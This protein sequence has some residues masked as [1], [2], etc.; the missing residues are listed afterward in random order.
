M[1]KENEGL[2]LFNVIYIENNLDLRKKN[3]IRMQIM[4]MW[5]RNGNFEQWFHYSSVY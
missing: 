4:N 3:D 1:E 5:K 2:R